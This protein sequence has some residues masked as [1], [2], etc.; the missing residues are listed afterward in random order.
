M[1]L[2]DFE[3]LR[4]RYELLTA[5]SRLV[6]AVLAP[7]GS[8]LAAMAPAGVRPLA[9]IKGGLDRA[10]QAYR[11]HA[12]VL[13]DRALT[14][15]YPRL[16]ERME[17]QAE[18]S[19]AA[20]AWSCWRGNAPT[21]GDLGDWGE[22]LIARLERARQEDGFPAAWVAIARMEWALH[23]IERQPD[24]GPDLS[25]L[26]LLGRLSPA[27]LRLTLS[28]L[29]V[30]QRCDVPELAEVAALPEEACGDG[31][32]VA[33]MVWRE[34]WKGAVIALD[35]PTLRWCEALCDGL[36]LERALMAAGP[37][38]DFSAW[39]PAAVRRG[40]LARVE[41]VDLAP[42]HPFKSAR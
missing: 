16:R 2:N 26:A 17:A 28:D 18:G 35:L 39:L 42:V 24:A 32:R 3:E 22:V 9:G 5:Q 6:D 7:P 36:D 8:E 41:S 33:L 40:W 31:P 1:P 13:A 15:I 4:E 10:L 23:R 20:L 14:A 38:F 34:G 12:G 21:Q 37:H 27:A 25:S 19:F 29:A 11:T 30:L